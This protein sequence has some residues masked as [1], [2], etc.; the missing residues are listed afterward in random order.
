MLG[1]EREQGFKTTE[2][3]T[4]RRALPGDYKVGVATHVGGVGERALNGGLMG[5]G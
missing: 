5:S 3:G 2:T 1:L 4:K